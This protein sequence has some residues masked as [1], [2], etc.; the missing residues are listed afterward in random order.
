M[1]TN[2]TS[3]SPPPIEEAS[4][5]CTALSASGDPCRAWAVRAS[6]PP[7]CAPHGGGRAPV[8]A[9]LGNRNA[10]TH[11]YYASTPAPDPSDGLPFSIDDVIASLFDKQLILSRYIDE[12]EDHLSIRQYARLVGLYGQ[13]ASCLGRLL[14][15]R[16]AL[17]PPADGVGPV[18]RQALDELNE[19]LRIEL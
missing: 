12:N 18:I 16:M 3:P 1:N 19:E 15:D 14:R 5:R 10:V 4:R 9:P 13:G 7:R 11:G 6:D 17:A 8:G 2:T